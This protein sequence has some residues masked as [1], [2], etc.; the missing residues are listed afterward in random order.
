MVLGL[1][2][3]G[4]VLSCPQALEFDPW[5]GCEYRC[6]YCHLKSQFGKR[7]RAFSF[8]NPEPRP[9]SPEALDKVLGR[10]GTGVIGRLISKRVT[11]RV[12]SKGEPFT[13]REKEKEVTR[14][15]LEV[16]SNHDYPA[17][18]STRTLT[19]REFPRAIDILTRDNFILQYELLP[20]EDEIPPN[21]RERIH[22]LPP[23]KDRFEFLREFTA[24]G[25]KLLL[26]LYPIIGGLNSSASKFAEFLFRL[27][28]DYDIEPAAINFEWFHARVVGRGYGSR[29]E[30]ERFERIGLDY[31]E[32]LNYVSE[33]EGW[34]RLADEVF[35]LVGI[36]GIPVFTPDWVNFGL[37]NPGVSCCGLDVFRKYRFMKFNFQYALQLLKR[38]GRVSWED[39][40]RA[41]LETPVPLKSFEFFKKLWFAPPNKFYS[42]F[43]VKGIR[44]LGEGVWEKE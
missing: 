11:I 37:R 19:S 9:H 2:L 30:A 17:L 21:I 34:R 15:T 6:I 33:S 39:M 12:G 41:Y 22:D 26:S 5:V 43:D 23:L 25:G 40:R 8:E 7:D 32:V 16:F 14:R 36:S 31:R 42:L 29:D 44:Y 18:I 38:R 28:S 27:V 13:R 20:A 10:P 4:D 3:R 24:S 1:K 35:S